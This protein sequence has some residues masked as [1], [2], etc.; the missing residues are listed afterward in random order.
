MT[1]WNLETI[2]RHLEARLTGDGA[3]VPGTLSMDTRTLKPG[4]CF[5]AI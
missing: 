1:L 5:V 4:A 2:A 3:F